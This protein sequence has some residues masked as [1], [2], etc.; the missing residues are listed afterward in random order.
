MYEQLVSRVLTAAV[1]TWPEFVAGNLGV[2]DVTPVEG[3]GVAG[4]STQGLL[5]LEL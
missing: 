1:M 5:E 4:H 3:A 2:V